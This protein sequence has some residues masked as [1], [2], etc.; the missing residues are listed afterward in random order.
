MS[1]QPPNIADEMRTMAHEPLLPIEKKLIGWS[2]SLGVVLLVV[3]V[4]IS[5]TLVHL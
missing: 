4:L 3:L 2:L 5:R 1:Q